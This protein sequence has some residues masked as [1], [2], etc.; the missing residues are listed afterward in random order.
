MGFDHYDS[1]GRRG[2]IAG[3]GERIIEGIS[4]DGAA[5]PLAAFEGYGVQ[6]FGRKA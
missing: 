2:D 3:R 4:V 5:G 1:T 6:G